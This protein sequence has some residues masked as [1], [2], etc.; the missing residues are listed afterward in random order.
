MPEK[1]IKR[2]KVPSHSNPSVF[3]TVAQDKDGNYA[4]SCPRWIHHREECKHIQE[5]KGGSWKEIGKEEGQPTLR[6]VLAN[7]RE[8]T[9]KKKNG[10]ILVPLIPLGNDHFVLTLAYDLLNAGIPWKTVL[11]WAHLPRTVN[12]K[13]IQEYIH[14]YGRKIYGPWVKGRG[15]EGY[16]IVPVKRGGE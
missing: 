11:E 16:E 15:H 6:K 3:H 7:V 14:R 1:W 12:P 4:C 9:V 13:M 10:E 5:V 2:W 8:V